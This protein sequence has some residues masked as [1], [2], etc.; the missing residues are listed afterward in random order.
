MGTVIG[1][2]MMNMA[3]AQEKL[4]S[5]NLLISPETVFK[6]NGKILKKIEDRDDLNFIHENVFFG[7]VADRS[8]GT[9]VTVVRQPSYANPKNYFYMG[10]IFNCDQ[11]VDIPMIFETPQQLKELIAEAP[12]TFKKQLSE[13]EVSMP[14]DEE[15]IV[16]DYYRLA[17]YE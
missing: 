14:F 3:Y 15:T 9:F 16:Y 10:Y 17:C 6:N 12:S 8:D 1:L 4:G 7:V 2:G 11:M 13:S 5:F